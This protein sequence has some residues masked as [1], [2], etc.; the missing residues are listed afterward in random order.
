M[1]FIATSAHAQTNTYGKSVFLSI[2][3]LP[4]IDNDD[5]LAFVLA[6]ELAHAQEGYGGAFKLVTMSFNSKKYEL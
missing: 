1:L 5:E 4:Y 3:M 2:G 6:H